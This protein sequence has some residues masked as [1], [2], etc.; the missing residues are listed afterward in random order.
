MDRCPYE[1]IDCH[2]QDKEVASFGT[3]TTP[4]SCRTC[5]AGTFYNS[6]ARE[7]LVSRQTKQTAQDGLVYNDLGNNVSGTVKIL[8]RE[9][10]RISREEKKQ[11]EANERANYAKSLK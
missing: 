8:Y 5:A 9:L 7:S 6:S 11:E 3:Y 2:K 1:W 10:A 4:G